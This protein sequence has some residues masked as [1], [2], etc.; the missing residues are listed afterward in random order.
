[1]AERVVIEVR[2]PENFPETHIKTIERVIETCDVK[3]A[4]K[5]APMFENIIVRS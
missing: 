3:Q 2:L 1:M 4:W 5:H